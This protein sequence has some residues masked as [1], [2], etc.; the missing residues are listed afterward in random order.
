MSQANRKRPF[1][2]RE[3]LN[4]KYKPTSRNISKPSD[5]SDEEAI[6]YFSESDDEEVELVKKKIVYSPAVKKTQVKSFSRVECPENDTPLPVDKKPTNNNPIFNVSSNGATN[7]VHTTK[8]FKADNVTFAPETPVNMEVAPKGQSL[9]FVHVSPPNKG[10]P[11]SNN[12][13]A[14]PSLSFG[15]RSPPLSNNSTA[16]NINYSKQINVSPPTKNERS[17]SL[18]MQRFGD[19]TIKMPCELFPNCALYSCNH[20]LDALRIFEIEKRIVNGQLRAQD[21]NQSF[22]RSIESYDSFSMFLS[23]LN[24]KCCVES[25]LKKSQIKLVTKEEKKFKIRDSIPY[26]GQALTDKEYILF[27]IH[28]SGKNYTF[29]GP[30]IQVANKLITHFGKYRLLRVSLSK[31]NIDENAEAAIIDK[32]FKVGGMEYEFI[33]CSGSG[34]R[35]R[36]FYCISTTGTGLTIADIFKYMGDFSNIPTI[37]KLITRTSLYFSR[38]YPTIEIPLSQ[39]DWVDDIESSDKRYNFTDGCGYIGEELLTNTLKELGLSESQMSLVSAIQIRYLGAKGVLLR[40]PNY[41]KD[42]IGIPKSMNKFII[43]NPTKEQLVL[44]VLKYSQCKSIKLNRDLILIAQDRGIP[45]EVFESLA[46]NELEQVKNISEYPKEYFLDEKKKKQELFVTISNLLRAGFEITEP[47]VRYKIGQYIQNQYKTLQ[48][49]KFVVPSSAYLMGVP[50]WENCL[51]EGQVYVRINHDQ[52]LVGDVLVGRYPMVTNGDLRKVKAVPHPL[53]NSLTNVIVFPVVGARPIQDM[54]SGGDLDGDHYVVIWDKGFVDSFQNADP[55]TFDA[56]ENNAEENVAT[57]DILV[58]IQKM[59]SFFLHYHKMQEILEKLS[60]IRVVI[61]DHYVHG[62]QDE[63]V[64]ETAISINKALDSTK[65]GLSFQIPPYLERFAREIKT[66]HYMVES[67][68]DESKYRKSVSFC[69]RIYD[70]IENWSKQEIIVKN[71][72]CLLDKDINVA[73][74]VLT[75]KEKQ[76]I[77][78]DIERYNREVAQIIDKKD[79][80]ANLKIRELETEIKKKYFAM[81]PAKMLAVSAQF[82]C[83]TYER[84]Y[85]KVHEGKGDEKA[86]LST[87]FLFPKHLMRIKA[88]AVENERNPGSVGITFVDR[89]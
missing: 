36:Q 22:I 45:F 1:S 55:M 50:D 51:Q 10:S 12:S 84:N 56:S 71:C 66:P 59:K 26:V 77:Q 75:P 74:D 79:C 14:H 89:L 11:S 82:Y 47:Y 62:L 81:G 5:S 80:D 8:H 7:G 29:H 78:D 31:S 19:D 46:K 86:A 30:N 44:G 58:N 54:L 63:I 9:P 2:T 57:K 13:S 21:V 39:V 64:K 6:L 83:Y 49:F 69:G 16:R 20:T 67:H 40:R 41:A 37:S 24:E 25:Y 68:Q 32:R 52:P 4:N 73:R 35:E 38:A 33:T 70:M 34:L 17:T 3:I 23:K 85:L 76:M 28:V 87:A 61:A 88:D 48:N 72:E 42:R 43:H 18:K 15:N 65:T 53:L 27:E 60:I